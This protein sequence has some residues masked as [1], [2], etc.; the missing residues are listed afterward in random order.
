MITN[1]FIDDSINSSIERPLAVAA[2]PNPERVAPPRPT[3]GDVRGPQ[4]QQCEEAMVRAHSVRTLGMLEEVLEG[5]RGVPWGSAWAP[6]I[7]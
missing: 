7:L 6:G 4:S 5:S 3:P 1:E 2:D